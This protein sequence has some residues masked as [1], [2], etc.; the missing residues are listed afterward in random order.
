ML[1]IV[2][3]GANKREE[4]FSIDAML[5]WPNWLHVK[6]KTRSVI[7]VFH[8]VH[9]SPKITA[10]IAMNMLAIF[11][12]AYFG[13][14]SSWPKK[15]VLENEQMMN[16][17][18]DSAKRTRRTCCERNKQKAK[19]KCRTSQREKRRTDIDKDLAYTISLVIA[20]YS[21]GSDKL[22]IYKLHEIVLPS[23]RIKCIIIFSHKKPEKMLPKIDECVRWNAHK[24]VG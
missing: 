15:Q 21:G 9:T 23:A 10:K 16:M 14:Y 24:C 18:T 17:E 1:W 22:N 20:A 2:W 11:H 7:V 19:S 4:L 5:S 12:I 8:L 6:S 3:K 13:W